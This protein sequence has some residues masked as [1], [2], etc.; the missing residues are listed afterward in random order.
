GNGFVA[1]NT[2]SF[3]N[4]TIDLT[5]SAVISGT[6]GALQLTGSLLSLGS[7]NFTLN[8]AAATIT[9]ATLDA[10]NMVI[11]NGSGQFFRAIPASAWSN[12]YLWPIGT[13]TEYNP[14][15]MSFTAAVAGTIG[16]KVVDAV[17]PSMGVAV[18]NLNVYWDFTSTGLTTYTLSSFEL[19][20]NDAQVSGS[21]AGLFGSLFSGGAWNGYPTTVDAVNN[22]ITFPSAGTLTNVT[23]P[24]NGYS[25]TGRTANIAYY[26]TVAS[27]NWNNVATWEVATDPA[28]TSPVPATTFPTD[29]NNLGI[30]I[31][32]AHVVQVTAN[33]QADQLTIDNTGNS[34]LNVNAGVVFTLVDG[35]GTD[36]TLNTNSRLLV[37]GEFVN[38]G[39]TSGA[40]TTTMN[41]LATGTYTHE[42]NGGV[43]PTSTWTAGSTCQ[44]SGTTT[45]A[46][47]GL[48]QTFK[49]VNWNTPGL[50]VTNLSLAS[51][52]TTINENL[53]WTNTGTGSVSFGTAAT[54]I[55]VGGD[56]IL[57]GGTLVLNSG[58][59]VVS[60]FNLT[61]NYNQTG[62]TLNCTATVPS[63]INFIGVSKTYTQ[64]GGVVTNTMINYAVNAAG[65]ILTLNSGITLYPSRTFNVTTG[66]L[67]M[68]VQ[69]I[70]GGGAFNVSSVATATLIS[71]SPQGLNSAALSG[72]VQTTGGRTFG[73]LANYTFAG[74]SPQ[75]TGDGVTAA[76]TLT[77]NNASGVAASSA[78][79]AVN[80]NLS[81]GVFTTTTANLLT[82]TGIAV[83]GGTPSAT[84]CVSGPVDRVIPANRSTALTLLY[85]LGKGG[86][87]NPF[88]LVNPTTSAG[89]SVTIRAEV[90]NA[91]AGGT[92]GAGFA[93]LNTNRYWSSSITAGAANLLTSGAIKLT[94]TS[95]ALV[96]G[97]HGIGQSS[98]I[99][100]TYAY[101][102]G[103]VSAPTIQTSSTLNPG[104]G[105]FVIGTIGPI[106]CPSPILVVGPG[107]DFI[108]LTDA[109][110][111][112]NGLPI[113]CNLIL[114]LNASYNPAL[115]TFP[116]TFNNFSYGVG[117]PFT[118]TV[119]PATGSTPTVTG[120]SATGLITLNGA[121]YM[122]FDGRPGGVGSPLGFSLT[123]TNVS[124]TTL[125]LL[126]DAQ[127]NSI[128]YMDISGSITSGTS[129]VISIGAANGSG[130]GNDNNLFEY[131]TIHGNVARPV[132]LMYAT[133]TST[134][135][136]D[137]NTISNNNFHTW[138]SASATD[139]CAI[140]IGNYNHTYTIN[141]NSFYQP[142]VQ[143][144]ASVHF[145]IQIVGTSSATSNFTISN[146]YFGGN[147][148]NAS[149]TWTATTAGVDY[150]FCGISY[151]G[152]TT[153][154]SLFDANTIR[155]FTIASGTGFQTQYS[156]FSGIFCQGGINT[157]QN[158]V[159]GDYASAGNIALTLTPSTTNIYVHG[160]YNDGNLGLTITG[161]TVAGI[162][163]TN[164][165]SSTQLM[166]LMGIRASTSSITTGATIT[167]N[168][169]GNPA[170]TNSL[171]NNTGNT[172]TGTTEVFTVGIHCNTARPSTISGNT[173]SSISY[174]A[175]G[176]AT[177]AGANRTV[178]IYRQFGGDNFIEN[179][180]ITKITSSS[181][182]LLSGVSTSVAGIILNAT[183][184][185]GQTVR[186]NTIHTISNVHGSAAVNV[187]GIVMNTPAT[188]TVTATVYSNNFSNPADWTLNTPTG[189]EGGTP[190]PWSI[191][192]GISYPGGSC[193]AATSNSMYIRCTGFVCDLLGGGGPIYQ[194]GGGGFV[195]DRMASSANNI[196]TVGYTS[197]NLNFAW[198]CMGATTAYGTVRYSIDGGS[199]WVDLPTQYRNQ[200]TWQCASVALPA[201]CE[202]ISTLRVAFRWRNGLANGDIDPPF[203]IANLSI[204][205][206]AIAAVENAADKN[207]IHS[208]SA[209]TSSTTASVNGIVQAGGILKYRNNMI[210][211]GINDAGASINTG[212]TFNGIL[213]SS[214]GSEYFHNS[215]YV[216]GSSTTG[217]GNSYCINSVPA[218]GTRD[219]RNNILWN[220]RSN[221]G[222]TGK[223]YA[224][225]VGTLTNLTS[226]YN[227]LQATGS[228]AILMANG[229]T[230][231]AFLP[232]WHMAT[233]MDLHSVTGDPVFVNATGNASVVDLH[234]TPAAATPIEGAG[235]AVGTVTT[236]YDGDARATNTPT[237]IGAD[238]GLFTP[239]DVTDPAITYTPVLNQPLCSGAITTTVE[240]NIVDN[241]T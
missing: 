32:N 232:L 180:T 98:T 233:M 35:L 18:D 25:Y 8:N 147:A 163:I 154:T 197:L 224:L 34:T 75:V 47:T 178:G 123:N 196:S 122:I 7:N 24:L 97:T 76:T 174:T 128:R 240:V 45:T 127:N 207:F 26:R 194:T 72:N 205:G 189:S 66:T 228:G 87:Y 83:I 190:N 175:A 82:I 187:A 148:A 17:H 173:I 140:E 143:T 181:A 58:A 176:T 219:I 206:Q 182:S 10:S 226:D 90:F 200:S 21:E 131:N 117:G 220:A 204:D 114:E 16:V 172:Y 129:G 212:Y 99:G 19:N 57:N 81:S 50:T 53:I 185:Q 106:T 42:Q 192:T 167:G 201:E 108:S 55:N 164:P 142:S 73:V 77:I 241:Q 104:Y 116:V 37:N 79:S 218:T 145:G 124:G 101:K 171:Q 152:S 78:I 33:V 105:Y 203:T 118:V 4:A 110:A 61:G 15:R 222:G 235:E 49:N 186:G 60:T 230:D 199:N 38:E 215:I 80:L 91:N 223:H 125:S 40:S 62:G 100:G 132:N 168:I 221:A 134:R 6:T 2:V 161:N 107:G 234:I 119:R 238:A 150:R 153:G 179:N 30:T 214:G 70:D 120:A 92:S 51:S 165:A 22:K 31:R 5:T 170:V 130:T 103:T 109:S 46:P 166:N 65:A 144:T 86:S 149:G 126:N 89:G 68:D 146:N 160:I 93:S 13:T 231:Y 3:T 177:G 41:V 183:A 111:V 217:A 85:P 158:N 96:S 156:A 67:N 202:N 27:G 169:I 1:A 84:A 151:N 71:G 64:T 136:N 210:R 69:V 137:N 227:D 138:G 115:E 139:A 225:K 184:A 59:A 56:L 188:P 135:D 23:A 43:V 44:I 141:A 113:N 9:G 159:I 74:S 94:E 195:T 239:I 36:L 88:E 209:S 12:P 28:F 95:P 229:A 211:L 191:G 29:D 216:G 237:D 208:L 112:L 11:T 162:S 193:G 14:V 213:E 133:G 63:I 102:G 121:D 155:N 157:I 54:T 52:L 236:D 198:Q 48:N 20:Y 39:Q